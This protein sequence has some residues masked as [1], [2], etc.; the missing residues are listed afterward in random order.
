MVAKDAGETKQLLEI[1]N[2][3]KKRKM[4]VEICF[5]AGGR[6]PLGEEGL[7]AFVK[8]AKLVVVAQGNDP[9]PELVAAA[10]AAE[11]EK[12]IVYTN[13]PKDKH[14]EPYRARTRMVIYTTGED[15]ERIQPIFPNAKLVRVM[16]ALDEAWGQEDILPRDD[17]RKIYAVG[18]QEKLIV[19]ALEKF[20]L[21]N[22]SLYGSALEALCML[23]EKHGKRLK[24]VAGFHPGDQLKEHPELQKQV[25]H[26]FFEQNGLAV[27]FTVSNGLG[28][29]LR[30]SVPGADLVI[31]SL[32]TIVRQAGAFGIPA[33]S[34]R[35]HEYDRMLTETVG[36]PEWLPY[37]EFGF[38]YLKVGN[39]ES[40]HSLAST[41]AHLMTDGSPAM[42][43]RQK[44]VYQGPYTPGASSELAATWIE[45]A[46]R[47]V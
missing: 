2:N 22:A 46:L 23:K 28:L 9:A 45:S 13:S 31:G 19:I 47:A 41:M 43:A 27:E 11:Q 1:A 36:A 10:A 18:E 37:D 33:L 30:Q 20:T 25:Y 42:L 5:G 38:I 7:R 40:T 14:L 32:S 6:L 39:R 4:T 24:I 21:L 29:D 12:L 26:K 8:R 15:K 3:L 17:V 35:C 44:E 34:I 16:S